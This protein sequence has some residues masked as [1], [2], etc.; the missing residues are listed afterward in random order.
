M[1]VVVT[2]LIELGGGAHLQQIIDI[3]VGT[4]YATPFYFTL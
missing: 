3:L 1:Y 2:I 4:N